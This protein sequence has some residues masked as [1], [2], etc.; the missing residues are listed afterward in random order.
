MQEDNVLSIRFVKVN[1]D[2]KLIEIQTLKYSIILS[3]E[4]K[5]AILFLM[6]LGE[7]ISFF[8]TKFLN[9]WIKIYF[10]IKE[11]QRLV[12]TTKVTK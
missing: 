3:F 8:Q 7:T 5:V 12:W 1:S 6:T 11:R 4:V 9:G 10:K 2:F